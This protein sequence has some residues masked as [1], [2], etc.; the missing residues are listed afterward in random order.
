M[1]SRLQTL[2]DQVSPEGG[3]C[4]QP[5]PWGVRRRVDAALDKKRRAA[6]PWRAL[7]LTALCA[8]ALVLLTGAAAVTELVLAPPTYNVLSAFFQGDAA[9]WESLM[10]FQPV[11]VS[12]DNYTLT[13]TSTVADKSTLFYTF[14][15]EAHSDEAWEA[16]EL[17]KRESFYDLFSFRSHGSISIGGEID[18]ELRTIYVSICTSRGWGSSAGIR[19]NLMEKGKWLSFSYRPVSDLKLNIN[20]EGQGTGGWAYP[21]LAGP[22][23]LERL[24]L[25]PL[26]LEA[27]YTTGNTNLFP[28][29]YFLWEDGTVSDQDSLRSGTGHGNG[30][31]HGVNGVTKMNQ[32]YSF[33]TV[34]D[35]SKLEAV[36]FEGM[37]YP[38]DKGEPYPVDVD[39]LPLRE[40]AP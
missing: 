8:A 15:I 11:S 23:T 32:S 39:A 13:V 7:K 38:V 19:L 22:V 37:A 28:V 25:S 3:P 4:P 17:Q 30:N 10:N 40:A 36:V 16:L 26:T 31:G 14:T 33:P 12:D 29:L 21:E 6:H 2:W 24:T 9:P 1:K 20:A 34:Q 18:P 27:E 5:N 35:L